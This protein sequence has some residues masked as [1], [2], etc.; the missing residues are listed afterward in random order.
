[1]IIKKYKKIVVKIGSSTIVNQ[2]SGKIKNKWLHSICE[3]ITE[4]V[5][6]NIKIAVVS[7]GAIALGKS[8][9]S[10]NKP[11]RRLEDKQA[12]AA[13]GQIELAKQWQQILKKYNTNSAQL[14]LT[15]ND[16]E[17][18]R[19][20][21][22]ARKTITSLHNKKVIPIINENDT[23]ATEEIRYGDNDRLAA[24]VAQMMDADLL[25]L[26]SDIDGLY[27]SNP[28]T[29]KNAKRINNIRIVDDIIERM[30][31]KNNSVF[32]SGGMKTKIWAAKI[33]LNS[34]CST[35][36]ANGQHLNPLK[37]ITKSNSSWFISTNSPSRARK[38]WL[39]NHLHPSGTAI[40]DDGAVKAL[41]DNKSLLPAG[42]LEITGR[43]NRGDII[44]VCN[45][46]NKKIAIGV[47]AYNSNDAKKII[48]KKSKDI[49][50]I[51]GYETRDELIHKDDLVK[52]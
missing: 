43:F 9:I 50:K 30:A 46:Q 27:T 7:S 39:R 51:L 10:N 4:L 11:I 8:L 24:R 28:S 44:T 2:S 31:E 26:L 37:I 5:N 48:G 22:N 52:V 21:L 34:G 47:V 1:M 25:V 23:V 20:Y 49:L 17:E 41:H 42:I 14:L 38:Q 18:R 35:I 32:G 33:C 29:N 40:I 12:A 6:S 45:K 16:S 13:I 36:I 15:L 3:D 19:R